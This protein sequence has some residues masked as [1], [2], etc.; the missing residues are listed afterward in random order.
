MTTQLEVETVNC[1]ICGTADSQVWL[2]DGKLTRYVRCRS[3]GT[4]YASPR[5][6]RAARYAWLNATFSLGQNAVENAAGRQPALAAEATFVQRYLKGG[7]LLDVGCDLGDFF[8]WFSDT[9]W[10]RFGAEIVPSAAEYAAR[11][12]RAQVFTGTVREANYPTAYFDLVTMIDMLYYIDDPRA[13]FQEVARILKPRG[14]IMIEVA[15]QAYQLRRSRGLLCWLL[16]RRWTRL[17]TDS[18]YLYWFNPSGLIAL[19]ADHGFL[20]EAIDV[21]GSPLTR[22]SWRNTAASLYC[23]LMTRASRRSLRALTWA[24]KYCLLARRTAD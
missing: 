1:P 22:S 23:V 14:L 4:V 12:Y 2:E 9:T 24:P 11:E 10:E 18:S 21:I 7:R 3:C 5:A 6:S 15:G 13:D 16:E 20:V 19:L 8:R 17:Q